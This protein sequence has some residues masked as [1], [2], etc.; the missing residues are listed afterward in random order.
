MRRFLPW[1]L[2]AVLGAGVLAGAVLGESQRPSSGPTSGSFS[3]QAAAAWVDDVLATTAQAR[4]AQFGFAS[5]TKSPDPAYR[6]TYR[7]NGMVDFTSGDFQLTEVGHTISYEEL[8][9][10]PAREVSETS[11]DESIGIGKSLY[12]NSSSPA[13]WFKFPNR[14]PHRALGLD[15]ASG[16]DD[17]FGALTGIMPVVGVQ[18]LGPATVRGVSTYRYRVTYESIHYC[19]PRG[20]ELSLSLF[21]PTTLWVDEQGRIVQAMS[22]HQMSSALFARVNA[23]VHRPPPPPFPSSTTTTV[24]RLSNFGKPVHIAAPALG[25]NQGKSSVIV[26]RETP[27]PK[28]VPCRS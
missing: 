12:E 1:M 8:D 9:H 14:D 22:S 11:T 28:K 15:Q 21:S 4:S 5:A 6:S 17:A 3:G 2:V 10:Q 24:L 27:W 13:N 19:G 26:I 20:N 7:G 23:L 16:A 25:P 18:V